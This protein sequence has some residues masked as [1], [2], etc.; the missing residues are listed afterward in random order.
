MLSS[1]VTGTTARDLLAVLAMTTAV[2]VVAIGAMTLIAAGAITAPVSLAMLAAIV[3]GV[4]LPGV[5][6]R[7]VRRQQRSL[8]HRV[9]DPRSVTG[10]WRQLLDAAWTARDQFAHV[11]DDP[12]GSVLMERLAA[13]QAHIDAALTRCGTLARDGELLSRQLRGY[14]VRRLRR[15]LRREHTDDPTDRRART[16]A[17]ELAEADRLA[18]YVGALRE[19]LEAQ[20]GQLRSAAWRAAALR[21]DHP[22]AGRSTVQDLLVDLEHLRE[23]M[24][25]LDD[26]E[27]S[28]TVVDTRHTGTASSA[29]Q[30]AS[31][32]DG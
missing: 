27:R 20:V 8:R 7:A 22:D 29:A 23:A 14:H 2:T 5:A 10:V 16:L 18:A 21:A 30:A 26:L 28:V 12:G 3:A 4:A 17:D 11:V 1:P 31:R 13:H 24:G 6:R 25:D 19:R 15:D 9:G 32:Y